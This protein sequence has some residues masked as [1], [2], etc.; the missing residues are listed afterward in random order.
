MKIR[1]LKK[2]T[3]FKIGEIEFKVS[4]ILPGNK[5]IVNSK[6]FIKCNNYYSSNNLKCF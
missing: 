6:T 3:F 2:G 5:G 1:I 4:A